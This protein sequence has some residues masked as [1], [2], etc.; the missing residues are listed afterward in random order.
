MILFSYPEFRSG[1]ITLSLFFL[2]GCG[3]ETQPTTT[4]STIQKD[5][6]V[7]ILTRDSIPSP[8]IFD[9]L[10]DHVAKYISG[11][12]VANSKV[13]KKFTQAPEWK[14]YA[15]RS[16]AKWNK[17]DT[18]RLLPLQKWSEQELG[19]MNKMEGTLFYPFSGPDILNA[20]I[21]FPEAEQYVMVGLEP[22]GE[23][24]FIGKDT[25]DT[26]SNYLRSVENSLFS[27]L[28]FSFFR[29]V[30]MK[31]DLHQ[32]QVNGTIPLMMIFLARSGNEIISIKKVRIDPEGKL[33]EK[34][35]NVPGVEIVFRKD[36]LH[37]PQKV[38]YFSTDLSN[39]GLLRTRKE[40]SLFITSLGKVKTYLK[41]ASYL[42][43]NDFFSTIREHILVQSEYILQDDSGIPYFYFPKENWKI[44][45]YGKYKGTISLF[46]EEYQADYLLAFQADSAAKTLK[47]LPFG[48]GYKWH[49]GESNLL[50]AKKIKEFDQKAIPVKPPVLKTKIPEKKSK[51]PGK[52]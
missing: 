1:L 52:S 15:A 9:P 32:D 47:K 35:G 26:L 12:A 6:V 36:S 24:P 40:F 39:E 16:D 33:N 44:Q 4:T 5:T 42:M 38:Y 51:V 23:I 7:P 8:L 3:S 11:I 28:H 45:L 34:S 14:S 49:D 37:F 29:T 10:Y 21:F 27:I 17:Y 20:N 46:A 2:F 41:S 31:K 50:L 13:D 43:H 25:I 48:I 19:E 22:V 18:T 30:A